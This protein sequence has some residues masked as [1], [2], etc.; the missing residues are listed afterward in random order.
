MEA[1]GEQEM[2]FFRAMMSAGIVAINDGVSPKDVVTRA[3]RIVV[4]TDWPA[5]PGRTERHAQPDSSE[6]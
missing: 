1:L 6:A 5:E 2:F 4:G 3:R